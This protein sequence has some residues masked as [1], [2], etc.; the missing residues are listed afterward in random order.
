MAAESRSRSYD[1]VGALSVLLPSATELMKH[2]SIGTGCKDSKILM[3]G[4]VGSTSWGPLI[5]ACFTGR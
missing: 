2:I 1:S 4:S 3:T 5:G